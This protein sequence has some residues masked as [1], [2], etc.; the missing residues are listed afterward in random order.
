M[1]Y[2]CEYS[3][4]VMY[5]SAGGVH[6]PVVLLVEY[7]SSLIDTLPVSDTF[8][9]CKWKNIPYSFL[10]NTWPSESVN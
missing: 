8:Q 3:V 7:P 1:V 9:F 2:F 5:P 4:K 6:P 10:R